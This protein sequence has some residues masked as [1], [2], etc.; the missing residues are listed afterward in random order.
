MNDVLDSRGF[1]QAAAWNRI[2][3]GAW[4][5]L[6]AIGFIA[7]TMVGFRFHTYPGRRA[8]ALVIPTLVA[9]SLFL[10]SDIDCPNGGVIRVVPNNLVAL[11]SSLP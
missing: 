5:L 10:I 2:P 6:S 4:A 8:L 7:T 1:A 3:A 11:Q 9:I